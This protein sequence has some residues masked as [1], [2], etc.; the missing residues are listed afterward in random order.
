MIVYPNAK[1]NLGLNVLRKRKDG[2]HDI[3]SVFYP[4][5][6]CV[7]ILEIVKSEK[8]EFTKSGIE[9]PDGENLCEKAWRL[10]D[11]DFGIENVKIH[12]HKQIA[13][14][15]GLGGGSADASFT[16]KVL[17]DL[18]DLNLNN[19]ELEKYAL[20]LGADCPF[21]I[22][23]TPK[24]VEGIGEKMT[25]IDLDLS[26]YEIRLVN[27]DIH[28]STKQAYS[29]IVTKTPV[30]PVEKIIELPI[31]E[32]KGKLKND[33]EESIF[34]KHLQLEGIKDE[35]YK[36]GSIYSSMSGSGSIVFGIFEK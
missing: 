17:D 35:L 2:Y 19:K 10:L 6:E 13:I 31:I 12:L 18:F 26:N 27:P 7:D 28:I 15:A 36:Q 16:L 14:G 25:S 11:A 8:F 9:I 4:V 33:F 30:L 24:L 23:N 5:K 21:F 20:R 22:D 32:W 29:G 34:E 3:S 1:I